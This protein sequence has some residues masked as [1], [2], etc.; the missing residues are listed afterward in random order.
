MNELV[1]KIQNLSREETF[2]AVGF[3]GEYVTIDTSGGE[4]EQKSLN[5]LLE[6]PYANIE[7]L[8]QLARL[9]LISAALTPE[10]EEIT[11]KAI[12]GAGQKHFV[13]GGAEIVALSVI[14]L[15]AL[16]VIVTKGKTGETEI[17]RLEEKDGE[18]VA[19]EIRKEVTYGINT[20]LGSVLSSYFGA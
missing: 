14:A 11:R 8:E 10:Y 1:N 6:Q 5:Q 13:L 20:K 18:I 2:E 7:E 4:K 9:A 19:V 15:V 3:V 12:E 16:H 17:M